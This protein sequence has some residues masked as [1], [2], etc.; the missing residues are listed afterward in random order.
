MLRELLM[1]EYRRDPDQVTQ[2]A[3]SNST[4][5]TEP[6]VPDVLS[7]PCK[8]AKSQNIK[9]LRD[10]SPRTAIVR[11]LN[12]EQARLVEHDEQTTYIDSWSEAKPPA[13]KSLESSVGP[14]YR[15]FCNTLLDAVNTEDVDTLYLRHPSAQ[16]IDKLWDRYLIS[17]HPMTK[18]FFDWEKEPLLKRAAENPQALSKAEQAF[19]FAVYFITILSLS[20]KECDGIISGPRRLLLLDAFQAAVEASLLAV[21]YFATS[22]LLVL[23][24]FLL[25]LLAIRNRARPATCF[26]LMGIAVRVAQRIGLHRDGSLLGL[27]VVQAEER[28]RVWWQMQHMEIMISQVLGCLSMTLYAGWDTKLPANLD[29]NDIHPGLEALPSERSDLTSI[30]H[31]LWRYQ[32]LYQQR[33]PRHPDLPPK[34]F[35]WLTSSHVSMAQKDAFIEQTERTMGEMFVQHCK[36]LNPL[37]VSIQIG[38]GAFILAM[39]R[40]VHQP[41]VANTKILELPEREREEFLKNSI[42]SLEY[43][44]LG[45]TTQSVAQFRWHNESYFQWPAFV[46]VIIEASHRATTSEASSLWT[47]IDKVCSIHPKL[48]GAPERP[49]IIAIGRLIVRAWHKRQQYLQ[50]LPQQIEKPWCVT[51]ME[52]ELKFSVYNSEV[53][54]T[55]LSEDTD[56]L[57][58]FDFDMIDWSACEQDGYAQVLD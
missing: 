52:R 55:D 54:G 58:N 51:K 48:T 36:L 26:S 28:R 37:H 5:S 41:G 23:Q 38:I 40:V 20:D 17:V 53:P 24:A 50:M 18:L 49:D 33:K 57:I 45:Q 22:D 6:L 32:V 21:E 35:A 3:L 16:E 7:T 8:S 10:G 47:L 56:N 29:D 4:T 11:S 19:S 1:A 44:I 15:G 12:G 9:D 2:S 46:Y 39:K 14:A 30:S 31:C 27:S 43:Y 13:A 25:Y 42:Q 34:D